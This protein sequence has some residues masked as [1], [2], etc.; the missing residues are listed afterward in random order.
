MSSA[1]PPGPDGATVPANA[2]LH[3]VARQVV[4]DSR[5]QIPV[6]EED[7]SL[8][9]LLDRREALVVLYGDEK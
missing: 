9:G 1:G 6:A 3:D 8:V 5:E 2:V 4:E 7:G